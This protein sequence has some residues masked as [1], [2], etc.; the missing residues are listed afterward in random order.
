M[1][2]V[3]NPRF[4]EVLFQRSDQFKVQLRLEAQHEVI[5]TLCFVTQNRVKQEI[6]F[7]FLNVIVTFCMDKEE[8]VWCMY[9]R[10]NELMKGYHFFNDQEY[11]S[12]QWRPYFREQC[13]KEYQYVLHG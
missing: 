4:F 2:S 5:I 6:G 8:G 3:W 1:A 10:E 12:N 13:Q 11:V 7:L 9:K